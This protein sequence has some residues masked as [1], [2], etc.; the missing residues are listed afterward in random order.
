MIFPTR[1]PHWHLGRAVSM[2]VMQF[3][4]A[5]TE[6]SVATA[7]ESFARDADFYRKTWNSC[8]VSRQNS[9]N[10][11][12]VYCLFSNRLSTFIFHAK[13]IMKQS[14]D[15]F[16][17]DNYLKSDGF[18]TSRQVC[19]GYRL[20][21]QSLLGFFAPNDVTHIGPT[22]NPWA[23]VFHHISPDFTH[24][25][26]GY[27]GQPVAEICQKPRLRISAVPRLEWR[28]PWRITNK[29]NRNAT[30]NCFWVSNWDSLFTRV[31]KLIC[32]TD[33]KKLA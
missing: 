26:F 9:G 20:C 7:S 24:W 23:E 21:V 32:E 8:I 1:I 14:E 22:Q 10:L 18:F 30:I 13:S 28:V 15:F 11:I 31:A 5:K 12:I 29:C 27:C 6:E 33:T 25:N 19:W 3:G 4:F 17:Q 2:E 16:W